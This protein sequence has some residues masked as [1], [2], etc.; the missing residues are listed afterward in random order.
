MTRGLALWAGLAALAVVVAGVTIAVFPHEQRAA[1]PGAILVPRVASAPP[2]VVSFPAVVVGTT[3]NAALT[4]GGP[5][6]QTAASRDVGPIAVKVSRRPATLHGYS[7]APRVNAT[8][9]PVRQTTT[10]RPTSLGGSSAPDGDVGLAS[11]GSDV[12]E[13]SP[14]VCGGCP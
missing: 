12:G 10:K 5:A 3:R 14:Q 2:A 1:V 11:G 9:A 7:T 4:R 8:P 13:Q 6:R